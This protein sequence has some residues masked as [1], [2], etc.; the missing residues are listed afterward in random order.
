M[1]RRRRK[2][3]LDLL[4]YEPPEP[5][6]PTPDDRVIE[7]PDG[8]DDYETTF[9][10]VVEGG[11]IIGLSGKNNANNLLSFSVTVDDVPVQVLTE[12]MPNRESGAFTWCGAVED[13]PIGIHTIKIKTNDGCSAGT[14]ALRIIE[15]DPMPVGWLG[16]VKSFVN[17][18][19]ANGI[20]IGLPGTQVGSLIISQ[21]AWN[22]AR[23]YPPSCFLRVGTEYVEQ[24]TV[25]TDLVRDILTCGFFRTVTTT[26]S[27][28]FSLRC[29]NTAGNTSVSLVELRGITLR[30]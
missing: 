7:D 18:G 28:Y 4:P 3:F 24:Q 16:E 11:V 5:P 30:P 15:T 2:F 17:V 9:E 29:A 21:S 12:G 14:A 27:P 1:T 26:T 13:L 8:I 20:A 25:R 6:A 10:T 22:S 19:S 23:A